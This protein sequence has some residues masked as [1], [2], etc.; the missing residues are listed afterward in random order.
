MSGIGHGLVSGI[1]PACSWT[2][3]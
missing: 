2:Y 1:I 3:H